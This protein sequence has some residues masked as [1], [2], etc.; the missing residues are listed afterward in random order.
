MR[1][2]SHQSSAKYQSRNGPKAQLPQVK[3]GDLVFIKS[4]FSKNKARDKYI[5]LDFVPN[6]NEVNVQKLGEDRNMSNVISVQ[7]QNIYKVIP[8]KMTV[9]III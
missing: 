1:L 3:I 4:D 6:K 2:K 9:M 8:Q 7:L 5:V